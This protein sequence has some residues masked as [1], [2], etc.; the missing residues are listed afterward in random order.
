MH[1]KHAQ[2]QTPQPLTAWLDSNSVVVDREYIASNP[3]LSA[4]QPNDI[5]LLVSVPYL[6]AVE[7]RFD[8]IL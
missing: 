1:I 5:E 7:V 6:P 2:W 3:G 8:L 4:P